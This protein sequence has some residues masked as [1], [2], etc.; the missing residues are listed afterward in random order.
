M[1]FPS[2]ESVLRC[3]ASGKVVLIL[4]LQDVKPGAKLALGVANPRMREQELLKAGFVLD[5]AIIQ[6]L[7]SMEVPQVF[8]EFPGLDDLDSIILS[9]LSPERQEVY[10]Q[11]KQTIRENE[12]SA[13]PVVKFG[14]YVEATRN[15][16]KTMM[17]RPE[18]AMLLDVLNKSDD[19]IEH[20]TTVAHLAL[21][22]G[23]KLDAYLIR[24]RSR[25][26]AHVA[27]DVT[28]LGVAGMLHDIGKSKLRPELRKYHSLD[29]PKSEADLKEWQ[30]HAELGY[31]MI[32]GGTDA[33]TAAT[34]L[35]HHQHFDGTGFPELQR[36]DAKVKPSGSQ[37]HCFARILAVANLFDRLSTLPNGERR[38][39]YQ[40]LHLLKTKY[41]A[42]L[43]P[44]VVAALPQVI[45]PFSPGR[46]VTLSDGT[47][48]VVVGFSPYH[49]FQPAVKQISLSD[50]KVSEQTVDLR[51]SNL[52]ITA[53]DGKTLEA[54]QAAA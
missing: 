29:L 17:G 34:V 36:G 10:Q 16:V 23:L 54:L 31:Q 5:E 25:L 7:K 15:F 52:K 37:I 35:Q 40:V 26:P 21:V 9:S 18:N 33:T 53:L 48:G 4:P 2:P 14:A 50:M 41:A 24:E 47:H 11:V 22:I 45:P 20:A 1:L 32:R 39:N 43:D 27:K 12:Q 44:E 8:V 30:T 38:T 42:W 46:R 19:E 49:P 3:G 13:R 51:Q 6:R 28:N